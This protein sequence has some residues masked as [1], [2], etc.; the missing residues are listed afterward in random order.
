[1]QRVAN[2]AGAH[3]TADGRS[4]FVGPGGGNKIGEKIV[5]ERVTLLSAPA[6]PQLLSQPVDRDGLPLGRRTRIETSVMT[7]L[8]YSHV[9]ATEQTSQSTGAPQSIRM[10]GGTATIDDLITARPRGVRTTRPWH[11][12]KVDPRTIRDTGRTRNGTVS[13]R[14]AW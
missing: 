5:D 3:A 9:R 2:Q 10:E 7:E 11:P 8:D 4:S 14:T 12:R 6:D 1:M 13:S